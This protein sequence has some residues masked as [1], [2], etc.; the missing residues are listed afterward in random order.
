MQVQCVNYL[1]GQSG[2]NAVTIAIIVVVVIAPGCNASTV[3]RSGS[4]VVVVT[5]GEAR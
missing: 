5:R 1:Y 2:S 4:V 3:T